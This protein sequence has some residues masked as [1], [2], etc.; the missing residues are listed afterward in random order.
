[1]LNFPSFFNAQVGGYEIEQSLRFDGAQSLSRTAATAGNRKTFTVSAWV[2]TAS[3]AGI[4]NL[5]S[6]YQTGGASEFSLSFRDGGSSNPELVYDQGSAAPGGGF[7]FTNAVYRDFSA[8]LHVVYV[9]DYSNATATERIRLFVNGERINSFRTIANGIDSDGSWN[10]AGAHH[11]GRSPSDSNRFNGYMAELHSVDGTALDPTDFGEY[12]DNGVWRPIRYTGSHGTNGF[13]LKFDPSATNGIGHDHSGNGNNW[14][15]NNFST[16]GT[17]TDVMSDTPTTNW[18]TANPINSNASTLRNGNL[19]FIGDTGSS[20]SKGILGT[21]GVS[22]GKWYFEM[23]P[24]SGG[25]FFIGVAPSNG[26]GVGS[27][28]LQYINGAYAYRDNGNKVQGTGG[29]GTF[30]AYG[31]SY[32]SPDVISVALDLDNGAIYFAKNNTWQNSGVPTSGSSKTGA[33]FTSF[34]GSYTPMACGFNGATATLNFGQRAF[35]YTPPTG[36]KELNTSNLSAP[37]VKDGSEYFNTVLYT[38]NGSNGHAITGVGFQP[39]LVW[40]KCR[41]I[42]TD[43]YWVDAVR[44]VTKVLRSNVANAEYTQTDSLVSFD[45]DGFTLDDDN[46]GG[47]S[48]N[49]N[50]SGRTYAA[51]NWL[52]GGSGSS[53]TDGSITST[54]SANP[55]A[56][57]SIATYTGNG[58]AGATIGHGLGVAPKMIIVK[59]RSGATDWQIGHQ[60]IGWTKTLY[61]QQQRQQPRPELGTI[62]RQRLRCFL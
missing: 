55:S 32:Q 56:G 9:G 31:N 60:S 30:S 23:T 50:I 12:D 40:G 4:Q 20:L 10:W 39:D 33:A 53:N 18:C 14:T 45:S 57:F 28:D 48:G 42:G 17:G 46:S 26:V 43:H 27:V 21:I 22:S 15:P 24:D 6:A 1:M 5:F 44:G 34:S 59:Q 38:G 47:P 13:Y 52:A 36:Y 16:S 11:I 62:Q 8:W 3:P 25:T 54:V 51:W 35:A 19:E 41:N 58:T 29:S 2:K 37:T 7:A 61:L 49:F